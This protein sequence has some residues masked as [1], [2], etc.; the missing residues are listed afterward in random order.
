[1]VKD[2]A[3]A[4]SYLDNI[5]KGLIKNPFQN[6]D[7][8]HSLKEFAKAK[9]EES[10]KSITEFMVRFIS[11]TKEGGLKFFKKEPLAFI[12][13]L[14]MAVDHGDKAN[15]VLV[16]ISRGIKVKRPSIGKT[17]KFFQKLYGR[18]FFVK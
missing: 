11:K 8:T 3:E 16:Q 4:K 9:D 12:E 7:S 18:Q 17:Q 13:C 14:L 10:F 2:V 15:Y 1:M 5:K 6:S